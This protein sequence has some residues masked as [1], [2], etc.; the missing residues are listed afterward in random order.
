M[1]QGIS[2]LFIAAICVI[3]NYV[4]KLAPPLLK[5]V[6]VVIARSISQITAQ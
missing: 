3:E 2:M 4:L 5:N 6:Y 1:F